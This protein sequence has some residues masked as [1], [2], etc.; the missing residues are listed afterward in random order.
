MLILQFTTQASEHWKPFRTGRNP[1]SKLSCLLLSRV[2]VKNCLY[3]KL[4]L[5]KRLSLNRMYLLSLL[6]HSSQIYRIV[7][8][9]YCSGPYLCYTGHIWLPPLMSKAWRPSEAADQLDCSLT[10][11]WSGVYFSYIVHCR[12]SCTYCSSFIFVWRQHTVK[13]KAW[14]PPCDLNIWAKPY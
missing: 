7:W 10:N 12:R 9:M 13:L 5:N 4:V 11:M 2:W 8:I 1:T 3:Q 6:Q 14:W